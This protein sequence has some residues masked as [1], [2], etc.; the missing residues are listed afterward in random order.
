MIKIIELEKGFAVKFEYNAVLVDSF[1]AAF[2][3][4]KWNAVEKR[5]EVG[6]RS[7]KRLQAWIDEANA[8][9]ADENEEM[10]QKDLDHAIN[11]LKAQRE[12]L[13]SRRERTQ[14]AKD[15]VA[16]LNKVKAEI[17]SV[18]AEIENEKAEQD[19]AENAILNI[20]S[21]VVDV[22]RIY[23]IKN[24]MKNLHF[25][26][27]ATDKKNFRELQ[28]EIGNY[29]EK[30]AEIGYSSE[31]L[32]YLYNANFNRPDRDRIDDMPSLVKLKKIKE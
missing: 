5:W 7:G 3:S 26:R 21:N 30:L 22:N 24:K 6:S 29:I 17:E 10:L 1:K 19:K 2:K 9:L 11:V 31:A 15:L 28:N 25:N 4:G 14:N 32:E 27:Y 23:D 16:E 12:I 20:I 8:Y 13:R 18:K